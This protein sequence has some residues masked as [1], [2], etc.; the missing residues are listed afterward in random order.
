MVY[1]DD[2]EASAARLGGS[3]GEGQVV[4]GWHAVG[5]FA[6][7][8]GAVEYEGVGGTD[9]CALGDRQRRQTPNFGRSRREI[10]D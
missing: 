10:A 8:K 2:G 3:L 6:G 7:V 5:S 1:H 9:V 4:V